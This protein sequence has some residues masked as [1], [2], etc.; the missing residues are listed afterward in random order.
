MR[1]PVHLIAWGIIVTFMITVFVI[2]ILILRV[3][4]QQA[5]ADFRRHRANA[6]KLKC[7]ARD[8]DNIAS[9]RTPNG[10]FCEVD[11]WDHS[12]KFIDVGTV[13]WMHPL[14]HYIK[15]THRHA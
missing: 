5:M 15:T 2:A 13:S 11:R 9:H 14:N 1:D 10:Y 3:Y 4:A 8:C 7:Q 12:K 6:G